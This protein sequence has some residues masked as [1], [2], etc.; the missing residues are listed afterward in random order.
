MD[1]MFPTQREGDD[2]FRAALEKYHDRVV[3]GMNIVEG[4]GTYTVQTPVKDL[5]SG[6]PFTDDRVGYV[7][8]WQDPDGIIR[9]ARYTATESDISHSERQ[10][11]EEEYVSLSARVLQ[12]YGR[13]DL[14][15]GP[16]FH[17]FRFAGVPGTF[18]P[19]SVCD[20]FVP[21][22]WKSPEFDNGNVFRD[23]IVLIGAY[24]IS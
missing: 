23:K 8:F 14:V 5:I 10:A 19:H 20:I 1:L 21:D 7:N 9:R 18:A 13:A 4:K 6:N 16:G 12:K 22:S 11:G 3:F 24:G 2:E 17:R 15:P